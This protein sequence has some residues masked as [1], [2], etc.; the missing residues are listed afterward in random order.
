MHAI[1]AILGGEPLFHEPRHVGAPHL[2]DRGALHASLDAILDSRRL[3]NDGPFVRRLEGALAAEAGCRH[4]IA[5]CNATLALQLVFRASRLEGEVIMPAFT[6]VATAHAAAWESLEP[7][8]AD[9]DPRTHCIDP[10]AVA[11]AITP[12]TAAIVGVHVWGNLCDAEALAELADARGVPLFFDAAHA[13]GCSGQAGPLGALGRASVVSLHATKVVSGLEGG[14]VLTN[15]DGLAASLRTMRNFGF[16]GYDRVDSLGTNAKMNEF[17]AAFALAG[18]ADL[19]DLVSRNASVR[20]AYHRG[21]ADSPGIRLVE[22]DRRDRSNHHYVVAIVDG[23]CPL[24]RDEIHRVL[25]AEN[26]LARRY[27]YPG[28]HRMLPYAGR[29]PARNPPLPVTER[30]CSEVLVLPA[31]GSVTEDEAEAIARRILLACGRA[32]AI[33]R[34]LRDGPAT[35][36]RPAA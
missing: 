32:E 20:A 23:T 26:V 18:L 7:V 27:F 17:S 19:P 6:F 15:D 22:T 21:L 13:L 33:R 2:P 28:C 29:P 8:F 4:A 12:R 34:H 11:A 3:S 25:E 10:A 5:L 1:P 31:G 30:V 9:I 24:A 16:A 35:S 14:A 36:I